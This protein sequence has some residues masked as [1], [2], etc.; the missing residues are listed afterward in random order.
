MDSKAK[1]LADNEAQIDGIAAAIKKSLETI[2]LSKK[3]ILD[4]VARIANTKN[5]VADFGAKQ[6]IYLARKKRLEIEKAKAF[7][8]RAIT[9]ESLNNVTREVR[10]HRAG[11]RRAEP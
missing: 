8:E 6:Q 3:G 1:A 4:L 2:S 5:E 10:F 9:E 11:S 7:E